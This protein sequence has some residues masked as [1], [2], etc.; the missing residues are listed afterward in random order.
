MTQQTPERLSLGRKAVLALLTA[1]TI[2]VPIYL[3]VVRSPNANAEELASPIGSNSAL[4]VL[5]LKANHSDSQQTFFSTSPSS[6]TVTNATV[7]SMIENAYHVKPFQVTGVAAW[8]DSQRYDLEFKPPQQPI[9]ST[10]EQKI[11]MDKTLRAFLADQLHLTVTPGA[12]VMSAYTLMVGAAGPKLVEQSTEQAVPAKDPLVQARVMVRDGNGQLA[13]DGPITGLVDVISA[14]LNSEVIDRTNLKGTYDLM[15]HW[16]ASESAADNLQTALQ[17]QLGLKLSL[18][19]RAVQT[20]AI[21][22]VDMPS[23]R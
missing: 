4:G 17:D 6:F 2:V 18:Q 19:Q 9:G 15:L 22:Q 11:L 7:R 8:V 20:L 23:E 21:D 1:A 14:Q 16:S 3:G 13:M 10:S 12:K 5:S